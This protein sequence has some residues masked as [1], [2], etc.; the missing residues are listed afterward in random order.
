MPTSSTEDLRLWVLNSSEKKMVQIEQFIS[1][2]MHTYDM[3]ELN[4]ILWGSK[5]LFRATHIDI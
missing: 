1:L 3:K 4:L 2:A 5:T